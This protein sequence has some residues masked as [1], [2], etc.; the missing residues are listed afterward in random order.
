MLGLFLTTFLAARIHA[1]PSSQDEG[2]SSPLVQE[3]ITVLNLPAI[4][5][6][7]PHCYPKTDPVFFSLMSGTDYNFKNCQKELYSFA[8]RF[9]PFGRNEISFWYTRDLLPP[10][11]FTQPSLQLPVFRRSETCSFAITGPKL[12]DDFARNQTIPWRKEWGPRIGTLGQYDL[13]K[14]TAAEVLS[15][16]GFPSAMKCVLNGGQAAEQSSGSGE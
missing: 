2:V 1:L 12:L 8:Q 6:Y 13:I 15:D 10:S 11:G 4:S 3:D 9:D 7:E 16:N 5:N 14:T